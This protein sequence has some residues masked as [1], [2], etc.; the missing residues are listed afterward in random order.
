MHINYQGRAGGWKNLI[1]D[2]DYTKNQSYEF[3]LFLAPISFTVQLS[4]SCRFS[5]GLIKIGIFDMGGPKGTFSSVHQNDEIQCT[6]DTKV[7]RDAIS[8]VGETLRL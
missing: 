3:I 7:W 2:K 6:M 4:L 8:N 1:L 5:N